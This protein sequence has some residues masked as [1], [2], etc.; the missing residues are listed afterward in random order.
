[1]KFLKNILAGVEKN[2]F[3]KGKMFE[4]FHPV[5]DAI[6]TFLYTPGEKTTG[7]CHVRD[8]NDFKRMMITVMYA[9]IPCILVGM[10][11]VGLQANRLMELNGIVKASGW[12]GA[13]LNW[14]DAC[15]PM[16][17]LFGDSVWNIVG[18]TIHG[19][20]Y[21]IPLYLVSF[22][23]GIAWEALFSI[24]H[25]EQI[26][27]GFFV[28]GL[29]FPLTLP[30]STPLWQVAIAISFGVVIGKEIFGGT[31]R[32]FLNPALVARAFLF[33]AYAGQISGDKVWTTVDGV[34]KATPLAIATNPNFSE[35]GV[36]GLQKAGYGMFDC[37]IGTIPG[38]FG[39][40]STLACLI[41]MAFLL[42]VGV[43][44]WRIVLSAFAGG[45]GIA[46]FFWLLGSDTNAAFALGPF[47]HV[48]MGGFAFGMIFMATD[49]VTAALTKPGQYI[50]GLLIGALVIVIRVLNPAYP[51]GTMLVILFGNCC[52]PLIDW[53]I[54][55]ANINRRLRRVAETN[56]D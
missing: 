35:G 31:G 16:L 38:S 44:S 1:M 53:F 47:W 30:P 26:H 32:N 20:V 56:L 48:V 27:E 5:F 9:L 2:F 10:Y 19:A 52:A 36:L 24:I 17:N 39:E 42:F 3:S 40:T 25:R 34:S 33:F 7:K 55:K 29:I 28:T 13:I 23:V 49:P 37:F 4:Q 41:G 45:M 22:F 21:F 50:Y 8:C 12:Q 11:N 43:A 14:L 46:T 51:E 54:V 18:C 6:D 15:F